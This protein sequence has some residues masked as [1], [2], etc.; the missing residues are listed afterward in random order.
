MSSSLPPPPELSAEAVTDV[1]RGV[2]DPELH[3][4]LVSLGMVKSVDIDGRRV[5][6]EIELTTPACPLKNK[7]GDDVKAAVSGAWSDVEVEVSFGARVRAGGRASPEKQRLEGVKNII[8]VASGKGG[9]GKSTVA[10]NLAY[11]LKQLGA[12]VGL[13]D[14]DVY[15]PSLHLMT[16]VD[17]A[18]RPDPSGDRMLPARA[19]GLPVVSM[20]L[21][22]E[23][24]QAVI[25][26]GPMLAS[27]AMQLITDVSW[28]ELDYLVVDLPPG[29]GDVQLSIA[30]KLHV[31]GAV[32]VSTPQDIA[33]A[34]VERAHAMFD[35][36]GID[37]I[38][39]IENMSYFVCDG[40]NKRHEIFAS[41][42]ARAA[43][44]RLKTTFL[45][46][47]PLDI[48]LREGGDT[49]RPV[50]QVEPDSEVASSFRD[51]A[52]KIAAR[53]AVL[54]QGSGGHLHVVN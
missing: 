37:T 49:G 15:G 43:A 28:G 8:L 19:G 5:A 1:L 50:V 23:P 35:K 24:G 42:G 38:G 29:T 51:I 14:T 12:A 21:L 31:A 36:V 22:I 25:W 30:Q 4:D 7:I 34:D 3:R 13:A 10:V 27:A 20:G 40:C 17:E 53:L 47:L 54:A 46:A 33:L 44:E 48:T 41:G 16:G 32:V 39:V 9:V 6:V 18:P 2:E 52:G 11:A 45:G 26:R